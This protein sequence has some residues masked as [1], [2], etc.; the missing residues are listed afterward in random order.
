MIGKVAL[1]AH[2]RV[3]RVWWSQQAQSFQV[4][5]LMFT[6]LV[7]WRFLCLPWNPRFQ[8][9]GVCGTRGKVLAYRL[10]KVSPNPRTPWEDMDLEQRETLKI[11]QSRSLARA[12]Q[13]YRT[14]DRREGR[15]RVHSFHTDLLKQRSA[16][17]QE[18]VTEQGR[19]HGIKVE[20]GQ[21]RG[22]PPEG[23]WYELR[24]ERAE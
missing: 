11:T 13:L 4:P 20:K 2:R 6:F 8:S 23:E 9:K 15:R 3:Y 19:S 16:Q 12:L 21:S 7:R 24:I 5:F 18:L 14:G 10:Q 22:E 17:R 1:N